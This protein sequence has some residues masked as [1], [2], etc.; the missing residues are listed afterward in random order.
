MD[1]GFIGLGKMGYAMARNLL[2]AGHAVTA[3]NRTCSRAAA[4]QTNGATVAETPADACK[5][6]AVITCL[7]DDS[8]VEAVAFGE[9]GIARALAAGGTHISMST[10]S[11]ALIDR[12]SKAHQ[13]AGQRFVAAPVFG[14]PDAAAPAR[15]LVVAAGEPQTIA[16]CQPLFAAM[17]QRT[18]T[19]GENPVAASVV[20]LIGNFLLV[21][22]VES[23]GEA[24]TLLRKSGTDAQACMDFLTETLFAAPV[25]KNYAG[26]MLQQNYEPGFKLALGLKDVRLALDAAAS[27]DVPM[28]TASL[29]QE[30]L[31]KGIEQGK[32][33]K[34]LAALEL[35]SADD[36][37]LTSPDE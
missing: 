25:Y 17:G 21:S 31:L 19:V 35:V 37:G 10:I 34:D 15:L 18:E 30:R 36:A 20:K 32:G 6:E 4:L 33:E 14:R 23:L 1:I 9:Q 26:L 24:I 11:P 28:P 3:Y 29:L 13:E 12:L 27:L 7:A 8:A 2:N 5:G 16:E 22:A